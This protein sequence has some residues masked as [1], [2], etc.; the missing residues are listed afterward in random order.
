M[1]RLFQLILIGF[2]IM[3]FSRCYNSQKA[4]QQVTKANDKFPEIV[5]QIARDKYPCTDLLK[6]DTSTVLKD[7]I[8][9][10]DCPDNK[11][12]YEVVKYDTVNNVVTKIV[13]ITKTT[14]VPVTLP[15]K[16]EYI[17]KWFED[18]AKLK[19]ASV[20]AEKQQK[21]IEKLQASND[22]L[23]K[24][25]AHR[26]KENWFWRIVASFF[27]FLFVWRKYKQLTTIKFR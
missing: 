23:S 21:S 20:N 7:T 16:T 12:P 5:A 11:N 8:V 17:T 13:P 25:S 27:I 9:Y 15:V 22:K 26:G 10:I 24:Q 6:P 4:A 3:C 18:S 2:L 19:I 14:K 1:K